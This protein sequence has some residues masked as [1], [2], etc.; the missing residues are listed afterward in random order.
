VRVLGYFTDVV[1]QQHHW[2]GPQGEPAQVQRTGLS[3]EPCG[4]YRITADA[5]RAFLL[6]PLPTPAAAVVAA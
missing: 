6:N 4:H 1:V 5:G 3:T 2:N